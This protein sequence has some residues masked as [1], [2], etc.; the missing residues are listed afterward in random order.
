MEAFEESVFVET[1]K[2]S[3][4]VFDEMSNFMTETSSFII[5]KNCRNLRQTFGKGFTLKT[6][7]II[8]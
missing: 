3:I 8:L 6:V 2:K 5:P 1:L 7:K 4:Q